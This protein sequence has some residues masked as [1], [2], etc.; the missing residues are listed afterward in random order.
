[1]DLHGLSFEPGLR[2]QTE[3]WH[4][5]GVPVSRSGLSCSSF[6]LVAS[7]GHCKLCLSDESVG[8]LI[9]AIIGGVVS[10]FR[11]FQ[12]SPRVFKFFISHQQVGFFV[13]RLISY[14]CFTHK[15]FFHLWGGGGLNW[16]SEFLAFSKEEAASWSS[17]SN[18]S[19]RSV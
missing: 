11:V 6:A 17:V 7:F 5:F 12:L 8:L 16:R 10:H 1:M 19:L 13:R 9:Q 14:E 4:R 3:I 2:V 15:I 18:S